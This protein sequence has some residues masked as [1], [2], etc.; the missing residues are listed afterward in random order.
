MKKIIPAVMVLAAFCISAVSSSLA[1]E[2]LKIGIF[3]IQRIMAESRTVKGYRE[4]LANDLEP[5]K[6]AFFAKRE[7]ANQLGEKLKKDGPSMS[8]SDRRAAEDRLS[9]AMQEIKIMN[10]DINLD[11]QRINKELTQQA[12]DGIFKAV[13]DIASKENYTVIFEK[14]QAGVAYSK[15]SI[16]ITEKVIKAYDSR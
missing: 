7:I 6:K 5:K 2:T 12:V 8:A 10:E 4:K 13:R 16:D 1:A 3:D 15:G 11:F 9:S 14:N